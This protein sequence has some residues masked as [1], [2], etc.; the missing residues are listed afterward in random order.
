MDV[1]VDVV[2]PVPFVVVADAFADAALLDLA[3]VLAVAPALELDFMVEFAAALTLSP[4][5]SAIT[6]ASVIVATMPAV[7]SSLVCKIH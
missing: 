3:V 4:V 5:A 2:F 7:F 6:A 1:L